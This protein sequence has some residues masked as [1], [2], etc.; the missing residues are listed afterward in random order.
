[1]SLP[2]REQC[3]ELMKEAGMPQNIVQ[4]SLAVNRV[5][6]YL[7]SELEKR[8]AK[9]D[10]GLVDRAS[11]LH[12]LDKHLTFENGKHG[13]VGRKMLEEKGY[14]ELGQFCVS[15]NLEFPLDNS[16]PSLE[17]KVVFYAD[18]RVNGDKV[19]SRSER[20]E[21]IK[22]KY[23]SRSPQALSKILLCEK[24]LLEVEKEIF[25]LAKIDSSLG[26]LK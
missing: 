22:G 11:L 13:F 12:D 21:Y 9:I 24:F 3:F 1:M 14:P 8:G 17:H 4:H 2:S 10:A 23:G 15:H 20:F 16:F 25:L 19:V 5:A 18:K 7:A 26:G 6:V